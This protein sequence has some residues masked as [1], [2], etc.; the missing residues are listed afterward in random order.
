FSRDWSSDVCSSD[1]AGSPNQLGYAGE[2]TGN[3]FLGFV[4]GVSISISD[5]A[6]IT[7]GTSDLVVGEETVQVPNVI[8]LWQ[9]N[10]FAVRAEFRS[11]E[12]RVGKSVELG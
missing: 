2:F 8:N 3:L 10:M 12:R 7:D 5:Q 4:E 9:R 11:E 1:L 6:S